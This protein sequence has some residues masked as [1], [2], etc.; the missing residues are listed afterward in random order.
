MNQPWMAVLVTAGVVLV[1]DLLATQLRKRARRTTV[2]SEPSPEQE[3]PHGSTDG[4]IT[5]QTE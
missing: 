2:F 4:E 3:E 5:V 1:V